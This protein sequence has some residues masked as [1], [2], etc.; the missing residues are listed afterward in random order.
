MLQANGIYLCMSA[1]DHTAHRPYPLPQRKWRMAQRWNDLLFAHW[2]IA[3]EALAKKLPAGVEADLYD[4]QAW[5]GVVPFFMDQVRV[6]VVGERTISF[7]S[8]R[9]FPELNLRTY[10]RSRRT[11]KQGV[12]FFSLDASSLLAVFGAR[13]L[14]HLPYFPASM[15]RESLADGGVAYKSR[16]WLPRLRPA[17]VRVHYGPT[18]PARPSEPGDLASFLTE[19]YCLFTTSPRGHL[20]VGEIHH[21]QWP[22]QPAEA[23]FERNDLPADFGFALPAS[24]PVLHFARELEVFIWGLEREDR[25]AGGTQAGQRIG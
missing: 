18:G 5:L 21:Q 22:L 8:T 4:G 17:E 7:P 14:F 16:R 20:L 25:M 13:V 23:E 19:R 24:S 9:S 11:G 10:V 15:S 1:L 2:P 6:R 3:P 12:Y